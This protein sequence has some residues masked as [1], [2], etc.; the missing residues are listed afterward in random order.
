MW[1][2]KITRSTPSVPDPSNLS[3]SLTSSLLSMIDATRLVSTLPPPPKVTNPHLTS[4]L[5]P[6]KTTLSKKARRS[7]SP[8]PGARRRQILCRPLVYLEAQPIFWV[9][10]RQREAEARKAG[11]AAV[12]SH[13]YRHL[14]AHRGGVD[15]LPDTSSA[16]WNVLGIA[17]VGYERMD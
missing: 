9:A 15:L 4:Q 10:P 3:S 7:P 6:R 14:R 13:C 8:S 2:Y 17:I 12:P 11:R 5:G 16:V 1:P